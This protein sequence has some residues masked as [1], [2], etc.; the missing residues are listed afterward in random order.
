[1]ANKRRGIKDKIWDAENADSNRLSDDLSYGLE[2]FRE[3]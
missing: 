1:M 3:G 2:V